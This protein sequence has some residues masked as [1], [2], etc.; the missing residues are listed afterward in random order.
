MV[1]LDSSFLMI[2]VDEQEE[3]SVD[4]KMKKEERLNIFCFCFLCFIFLDRRLI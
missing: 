2:V 1:R 4:E 3:E